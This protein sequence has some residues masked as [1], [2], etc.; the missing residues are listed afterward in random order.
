M[1]MDDL[2][3]KMEKIVGKAE[4]LKPEKWVYGY[5]DRNCYGPDCPILIDKYAAK[6]K[7]GE[8]EYFVEL[9]RQ[10]FGGSTGNGDIMGYGFKLFPIDPH[11][12]RCPD[13]AALLMRFGVD[14]EDLE[15][16]FN[17][18]HRNSGGAPKAVIDS[19][20]RDKREK[21]TATIRLEEHKKK[22]LKSIEKI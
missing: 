13:E 3:E 15:K 11:F 4:R 12:R 5:D 2:K 20:Y 10:S 22:L 6:L 14:A 19:D 16:L 7:L 8:E 17:K 18:L 9:T 1:D 21:L